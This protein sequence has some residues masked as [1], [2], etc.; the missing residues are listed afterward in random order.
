MANDHTITSLT[1]RIAEL[2]V[3]GTGRSR[4]PQPARALELAYR[5]ISQ[6]EHSTGQLRTKLSKR[7]CDAN[8]IATALTELERY[9]FVDDRRYAK[10]F[11]EDKRRLQGWGQRRIAAALRQ[12]G[13]GDDAIAELFSDE[14]QLDAPTEREVAVE[15]LRRKQPD[16]SDLKVKARMAA[17]LARRGLSSSTVHAALRDYADETK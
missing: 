15:L 14:S 17:M 6:R 10:L 4:T 13:I 9:G 3:S 12:A 5:A 2:E 7:G 16:L 1:A 8:E 11:A